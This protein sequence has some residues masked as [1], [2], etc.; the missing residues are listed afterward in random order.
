MGSNGRV[1]VECADLCIHHASMCAH[2]IRR[3]ASIKFDELDQE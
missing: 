3:L 2:V 1:Q